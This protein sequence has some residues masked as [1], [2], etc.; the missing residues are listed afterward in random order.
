M[1]GPMH[2]PSL[3][4]RLAAIAAVSF[5]LASCKDTAAPATPASVDVTPKTVTLGAV[6]STQQLA[7]TV[8]D[9][10]GATIGGATVSWTTQNPGVASISSGGLVTAAGSGTTQ[11]DATASGTA[12]KGSAT[13]SV[14][15]VPAQIDKL[16]GDGQIDTVGQLLPVP[17]TIEVDDSLGH[18][19]GNV[20]VTFNVTLGGGTVSTVTVLTSAFGQ[21]TTNWTLGSTPGANQVTV[22]AATGTA[23]PAVYTATARAGKP[24]SVQ[25][26]SGNN[27]SGAAGTA[28]ANPV[29]VVVH[30][31]FNNPVSGVVVQYAVTAGGGHTAQATTTTGANG[32]ASMTWTLGGAGTNTLTATVVGSGISGNPVSFSATG[33]ANGSPKSVV[34]DTGDGQTGL[35]GYAVNVPPAV[36][37]L[38]SAGH[39]V[40]GVEVKF[41]VTGGGGSVT[42][43]TDTTNTFGVAAVGS[44]TI[45]LGANTLSA[46]VT[47]GGITNNPITFHAAGVSGGFKIDLVFL[48]TMTSAESAAFITAKARWEA[49]IYQPVS[50]YHVQLSA[51]QC[52]AGSPAIDSTNVTS[53]VIYASIIPIDGVGGILGQAGPC[54]LR[55]SPG[56]LPALGLMQFDVADVDTLVAHGMFDEVI[57]HE[58]A[59]VLGYGTIWGGSYLNLERNPCN[60]ADP[61]STDPHFV[62]AQATAAFLQVGGSIYT[63]GAIVPVEDSGGLGTVDAHWRERVLKNELMTGYLNP[64]FNPLSVVSIGS[65]QDLGYT[66][67]YGAADPYVLS[68]PLRAA[69]ALPQFALRNDV[70]RIPMYVIDPSGRVVRVI[71]P[72]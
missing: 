49:A 21:A 28:L 9:A 2:L 51:G 18:P 50:A 1:V 34:V 23:T 31:T 24:K 5:S 15:Q 54:V 27:Q 41:A 47:G 12:V 71:P 26:Q 56:F 64:G 43:A 66:V 8:K 63:G 6:G 44:W 11:I 25:I 39:P 62:G 57:L 65:M 4:S 60:G 61:C 48:S 32:Q 72:Q 59:H 46:T 36:R 67:N 17:L 14:A 7:A 19:V 45:T 13:V 33:T 52:G 16:S 70:L 20:S 30:D 37:V 55:N 42:S 10:N 38:D 40:A 22:T 3:H 53:V 58:M 29:V 35:T 68:W 69:T